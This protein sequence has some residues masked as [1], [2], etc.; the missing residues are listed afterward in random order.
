[1]VKRFV[2]SSLA[3][4]ALIALSPVFLLVAI[5]IRLSSR[6]PIFY[7]AERV[8]LL[9]NS[10]SLRAVIYNPYG[11]V[12]QTILNSFCAR[13]ELADGQVQR[14]GHERSATG[15]GGDVPKPD[16]HTPGG[17]ARGDRGGD[18]VPAVGRVRLHDRTGDQ[19][20]RRSGDVVTK[21]GEERR[22]RDRD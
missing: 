4:A 17:Q 2:E 5:G 3:L 13:C 16:A 22:S 18:M 11:C 1:M 9:D 21:R 14:R 12:N 7:R 10:I 19:F 8:W 6:G 15:R 20:H